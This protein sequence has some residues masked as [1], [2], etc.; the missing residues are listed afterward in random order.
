MS[1]VNDAMFYRELLK[2]YVRHVILCEG[3]DFI[4]DNEKDI[5]RHA[6]TQFTKDELNT[7][8]RIQD[9]IDE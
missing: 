9:E 7:L 2:K 8:H 4:P 3:F 5:I 1:D 6:G